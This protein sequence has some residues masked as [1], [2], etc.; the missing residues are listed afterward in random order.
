[1][2]SKPFSTSVRPVSAMSVAIQTDTETPVWQYQCRG[3]GMRAY[4]GANQF[5]RKSD[6]N[7][8]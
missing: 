8:I 6:L 4:A 7:S 1:V 3:P 5:W 2:Q